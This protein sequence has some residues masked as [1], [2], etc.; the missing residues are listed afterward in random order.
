MR[1]FPVV[2]FEQVVAGSGCSTP[3]IDKG[4]P[5]EGLAGRV[6]RLQLAETVAATMSKL[7]H[8]GSRLEL[9][10]HSLIYYTRR[11]LWLLYAW[12]AM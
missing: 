10:I 4:G 9:H 3:T 12:Y 8:T 1:A 2:W 11:V 7:D 6:T 5:A